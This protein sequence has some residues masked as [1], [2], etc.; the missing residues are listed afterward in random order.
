VRKEA[1]FASKNSVFG[2]YQEVKK[3]VAWGAEI[4]YGAVDF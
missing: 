2:H 1:P 3:R 4:A